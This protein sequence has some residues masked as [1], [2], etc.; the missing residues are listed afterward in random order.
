MV[1]FSINDKRPEGRFPTLF[2]RLSGK[3][4]YD[5]AALAEERCDSLGAKRPTPVIKT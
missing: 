1:P 5:V 3:M 4:R 2:S